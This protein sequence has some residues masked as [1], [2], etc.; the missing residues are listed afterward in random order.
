[1]WIGGWASSPECWRGTLETLYPGFGHRFVAVETV[2]DLE[3]GE[4]AERLHGLCPDPQRRVVVAWSLGS[5]L[6]LKAW[7]A[8]LWPEGLGLLAVCPVLEFCAAAGPWK[9][10]HLDRMIRG[11]GRN[12]EGVLEEFRKLLREGCPEDEAQA[13]RAAASGIATDALVRGLEILRDGKLKGIAPGR[14]LVMVE[15]A[16]DRVSPPLGAVLD[17][18][19][20]AGLRRFVLETGHLPFL[21]DPEGF[22]QILSKS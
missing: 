2:Q 6:A 5:L 1:M 18:E 15:G 13:W 8:G 17:P 19:G 22:G 4:L 11:L 14:E 20:L 3:P 12:R 7:N 21:E 9:R 16:R 10:I